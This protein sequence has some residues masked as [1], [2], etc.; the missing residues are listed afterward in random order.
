[1]NE[2]APTTVPTKLGETLVVLDESIVRKATELVADAQR[3][4]QVTDD[5]FEQAD[6][7]VASVAGL[8]KSVEDNRKAVKRPVLALGKA[9]DEACMRATSKLQV[10]K[11]GL[12]NAIADYL[13]AKRREAEAVEARTLALLRDAA[14]QAKVEAP[15]PTDAPDD[16]PTSLAAA[17]GAA[18]VVL[19]MPEAPPKSS[20]SVRELRSVEVVDYDCIPHRINGIALLKPDLTAIRKLLEAGVDVPGATLVVRRSTATRGRV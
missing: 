13:E 4:E 19:D 1:M 17:R 8:L 3:I 2:L 14:E 9:I 12:A 15:C 11:A 16:E 18:T 7:L 5:N 20:V 10:A 6:S